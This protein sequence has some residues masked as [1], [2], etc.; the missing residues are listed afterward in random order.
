MSGVVLATVWWA[1]LRYY[2]RLSRA[3]WTVINRMEARLPAQ[4]FTEEWQ[5]L[6]ADAAGQAPTKRGPF[7]GRVRLRVAH[8]EATVVE[9]WV[10]FVFIFLYVILGIR[11]LVQ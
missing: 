11:A 4:P 10:P 2:R 6:R 8:R 1:L 9:Q 3:K 5:E 7:A